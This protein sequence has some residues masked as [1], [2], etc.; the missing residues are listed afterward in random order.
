MRKNVIDAKHRFKRRRVSVHIQMDVLVIPKQKLTR[1]L[2]KQIQK[3]LSRLSV[4]VTVNEHGDCVEIPIEVSERAAVV[5]FARQHYGEY[6]EFFFEQIT[7]ERA[8]EVMDE[9]FAH[10]PSLA[11]RVR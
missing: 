10:S 8:R 6:L 11:E 2:I 7:P 5:E 9:L 3:D 4:S 1:K